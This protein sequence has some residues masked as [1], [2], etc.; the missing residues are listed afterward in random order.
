MLLWLSV[1]YDEAL[2]GYGGSVVDTMLLMEEFGKGLL[3]EP[4]VA[5]VLLFDEVAL[6]GPRERIIERLAPWKEAG[7][8]GEVGTML[9]GVHDPAVLELMAQEI[10]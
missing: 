3:V 1:P 8:R 4:Y 5:T 9:M 10:L 6:V 7:K 2:G